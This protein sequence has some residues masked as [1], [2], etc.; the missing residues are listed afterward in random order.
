[1][2]AESVVVLDPATLED[3]GVGFDCTELEDGLFVSPTLPEIGKVF[4]P[5]T[6]LA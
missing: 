2:I 1:M 6:S 5:S 3:E 4:N